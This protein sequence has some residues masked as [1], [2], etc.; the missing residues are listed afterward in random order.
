MILQRYTTSSLTS[1]EGSKRNK[2]LNELLFRIMDVNSFVRNHTLHTWEKLT[3]A[4][5]VPKRYHI[6]LTEAVVGR[7]EDKNYLVR[8]SSMSLISCILRKNWFGHVLNFTL[9][10]SK[11][12][13][14][15]AEVLTKFTNDESE[16]KK[17]FSFLRKEFR[18]T[19]EDLDDPL[20][21][22]TEDGEEINEGDNT[23]PD[24][25]TLE[26]EQMAALSKVL[27]YENA[28]CFVKLIGTALQYATT[29]LDS[30]TER[31]VFESIKL[32][33]ACSE[34][35]LEASTKA[36]R[37]VLVMVFE[38]EVKVQLAVR[39]A[40][41]EVVFASFN[42]LPG[43]TMTRASAS[44]QRLISILNEASEGEISAVDRIF[45]LLKLNTTYTRFLSGPFIDAVWS[46]VEGAVTQ[47]AT[48]NNCRTAMR[49]Y[50]LLSKYH[51]RDLRLRKGSILEF[52]ESNVHKDNILLSYVFATLQ[53]EA[54]DPQFRPISS[55]E[56]PKT[57]CVLKHL[58][59]HLCRKTT[60]IASWMCLAKAALSAIHYLCDVPVAIYNYVLEYYV[61]CID[62]RNDCNTKSQLLFLVGQTAFKQLVA[63]ESVERQQLKALEELT[64]E[65]A[66]NN[67]ND[68]DSMQKE[69]GLGS[70]EFKRHTVHEL[71]QKQR[72]AILSVGSIWHTVSK[73]VV[74]AC[75]HEQSISA[76]DRPL[77]RV[78]AVMTLCQ[79][80]IIDEDFCKEHLHVILSIASNKR[81]S[82]IMK[83]NI[84]IAL[85]DLACVH[86]NLLASYLS[87]PTTGL[88]KM[89]ADDDKRVRAVTIQVC[90]HLVLG[91]MLRVRDHLYAIIRLVADP[92]ETIS[93]N[94]VTFVQ[95][96]AMR[97][98]EKI[99][100]LIPPLVSQLSNLMPADKFQLAV[101][102]L[103]ERVE[104]DKP[105]DSLVERLC[106]SFEAFSERSIKKRQLARNLAFCLSELNYTTDRSIKR[107]MSEACY[108]QYRHWLRD[109]EVLQLFKSIA[110]KAKKSGR[111]GAERRDKS[112][113][114]EWESRML[115]DLCTES[116]QEGT[117]GRNGV[118]N[119]E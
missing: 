95:N 45:S 16:V 31:D 109:P 8:D 39:D 118:D 59:V 81:E 115:A 79:L 78:C 5:A 119:E 37:K 82:W 73:E 47:E 101:R 96:L 33:V 49:I 55:T 15:K 57:H 43:S 71:A 46:V 98:K 13:E 35:S 89:L 24:P 104:G 117:E 61:S 106:Q 116:S 17:H 9:I 63:V 23:S 14:S 107:I 72:R 34:F 22:N 74:S 29:L 111:V 7:L 60:A 114:E 26:N 85:G 10:L 44:A 38:G 25:K 88:F 102:T 54:L 64:K 86:P 27:F 36:F 91:E 3:E 1:E 97:E 48:M 77:E 76:G 41:A 50:S 53:C 70:Y 66:S 112:A 83:T 32:I 51:W 87:V 11:L 52:L 105:T 58:I 100:N 92:D 40:F 62:T 12:E 99:G 90:S 6:A 56:N 30:R 113:I 75:G 94:A 110:V 68:T 93:S 20:E 108:Q 2:Y 42:R 4:K 84:V 69:L 28:L 19:N 67:S 18:P 103:L 65:P 80:M 21:A